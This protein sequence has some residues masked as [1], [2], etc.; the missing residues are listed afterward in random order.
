MSIFN[1]ILY[2]EPKL[3]DEI[4]SFLENVK[5]YVNKYSNL[6]EE[7]EYN[8]SNTLSAEMRDLVVNSD[9]MLDKISKELEKDFRRIIGNQ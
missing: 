2:F 6:K 7:Y 9:S 8:K 3:R 4:N 5:R 1:A